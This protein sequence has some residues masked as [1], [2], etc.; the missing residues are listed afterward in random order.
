MLLCKIRK[1]VNC[2]TLKTMY[3]EIF[4]IH[5]NYLNLVW[6]QNLNYMIRIINNI[7][8]IDTLQKSLKNYKY[9]TQE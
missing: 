6:G 4:D 1:Y 2:H 8:I 7:P 3:F 9:S 5:F